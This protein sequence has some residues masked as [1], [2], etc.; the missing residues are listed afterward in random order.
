MLCYP[1]QVNSV[2]STVIMDVTEKLTIPDLGYRIAAIVE[3]YR[4][5]TGRNMTQVCEDLRMS[6]NNFYRILGQKNK[7]MSMDTLLDI[8]ATFVDP[9]LYPEG[10]PD[11][12]SIVLHYW[13]LG[14][15]TKTPLIEP[16][17]K[18]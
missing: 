13:K 10:F 17:K 11:E 8:E 6:K 3:D 12:A 14:S 15:E 5:R 7:S 1:K 16:L 4:H 9:N 2:L 18:G